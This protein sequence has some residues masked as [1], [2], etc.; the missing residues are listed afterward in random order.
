L[1]YSEKKVIVKTGEFEMS[2]I[3]TYPATGQKVPI[4]VLV[5]GSGPQ[6]MDE[7][8]GPNK[9]FQ[10]IAFG[11]AK[12]GI[13]TL[14]YDK[15]TYK[16]ASN[17]DLKRITPKEEVIDDAIS[18]INLASSLDMVDP[19]RIYLLGHS[20]GGM[21]APQIAFESK[22]LKG[23]IIMAGV[24]SKLE[25]LIAYQF[26]YL[27]SQ[28]GTP[29]EE[30][31][32]MI[33]KA[34][35]DAIEIKKINKASP[36]DE[37]IFH[38]IPAVYWAYL[39]KYDPAT[40]AKKLKIPMLVLQGERDYQVPM[41]EFEKWKSG[42]SGKSNASFVSFEKLNHLFM[43]GEGKSLPKEYENSGNIPFYVMEEMGNWIIK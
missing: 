39:N 37:R 6:D 15:R 25:D 3:V 26:E 43:E 4:V 21:M 41:T 19:K 31:Q 11:L 10:D 29:D 20:L 13:A 38:N 16:Y 36:D 1:A 27:L 9:P 34:K 2:G 12:M 40:V 18:A 42:L 23:I 8:I 28:D 33:D 30:E 22:K 7:T 14:R 32:K 35:S 24:T 5:H 17:P